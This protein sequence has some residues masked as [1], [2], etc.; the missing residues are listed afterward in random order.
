MSLTCLSQVAL[1]NRTG[2]SDKV[3]IIQV[4]QNDGPAGTEYIAIGYYGKRPSPSS[5]AEKYRGPSRASAQAAADRLE[6]QKRTKSGY[7]NMS[8]VTPGVRIP[9]MPAGA[10]VFGG[11]SAPSPTPTAAAVA[12]AVGIVPMRANPLDEKDLEQY[13]TDPDWV[14]QRKYDGE[15]SPVSI[16]RSGISATNLSAKP[17]TLAADSEAS[18]KKLVARTDFSE[19]RETLVDGEELP[20][21]IF[22]IYDVVTLRDNDVRKQGF[23]ER[24]SALEDLLADHLGLLAPTAWTEAEKRAMLAQ[25]RAEN[26]E[27]LM[28]RKASAPYFNGRTSDILKFKLWASATCRVLT[29]NGSTRSVG[30]AVREAD[31]SET[32]AGNVTVPVNQ[33]IPD[34]DALVEVRYLYVTAGGKLYQPTLLQVRTDKDEEGADLRSTL[35]PAPPEKAPELPLAA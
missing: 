2:G 22:V 13:L 25:A 21:G 10:P 7:T 28:F 4:Q 6:N 24:F 9:G 30:I 27:G 26:W 31:G 20:G 11:V 19:E 18:L 33:D 34:T 3:Y 17:R 23:D 1:E 15:R 35:R 5:T 14:A 8:G 29:A 32:T 12:A 16:R